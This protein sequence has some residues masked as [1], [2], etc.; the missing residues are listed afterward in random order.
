MYSLQK[1]HWLPY[2]SSKLQ[3]YMIMLNTQTDGTP[4]FN[5]DTFC[6]FPQHPGYIWLEI[7][8]HYSYQTQL[9]SSYIP[10]RSL[11]CDLQASYIPSVYLEFNINWKYAIYFLI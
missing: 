7:Q 8:I 2:A 11:F 4:D 3:G 1:A 9:A 10:V 6:C 5:S